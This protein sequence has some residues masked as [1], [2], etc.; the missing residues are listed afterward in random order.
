M[1]RPRAPI[2]VSATESDSGVP[3]SDESP[4]RGGSSRLGRDATDCERSRV[5]PTTSP[6]SHPPAPQSTARRSPGR[7]LPRA[8]VPGRGAHPTPRGERPDHFHRASPHGDIVVTERGEV[9]A[10]TEI[11]H[12]VIAHAGPDI[13]DGQI[14]SGSQCSSSSTWGRPTRRR[15]RMSSYRAMCQTS[16]AM[17]FRPCGRS[18]ICA[19]LKR[20][21]KSRSTCICNRP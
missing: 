13:A 3:L 10:S 4:V 8:G 20:W 19:S 21:R 16:Q 18:R 2:D 7:R 14:E 12:L 9:E 17:E 1:G 6:W 11:G 5:G 15:F